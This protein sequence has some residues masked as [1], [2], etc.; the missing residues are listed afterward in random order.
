[1]NEQLMYYPTVLPFFFP[2]SDEH[3]ETHTDDPK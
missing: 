1:M 3:V 2:V